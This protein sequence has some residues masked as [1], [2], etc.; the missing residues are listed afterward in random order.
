ML[1]IL[2]GGMLDLR[3]SRSPA[4]LPL[5]RMAV[6]A[7]ALATVPFTTPHFFG[8]ARGVA[9][10][11]ALALCVIAWLVWLFADRNERAVTP[12]MIV[13]GGAGGVL[14]GLSSLSLA[15]AIGCVVT[16]SAAI[17]MSPDHSFAVTAETSAAF[18]LAGLIAGASAATL[19]GYTCAFVGLWALGLTRHQSLMRAEE[20]ER[21]LEQT[22]R[23]REAET[24]A[25]ALTERARLAR[26]IHDVLAH[27]LA[28]V[29]VNLQAAE[30][31][32]SGLPDQGPELAKALECIERAG[33][34][35]RE[36]LTEARHA[37]NA[38]RDNT[39]PLPEQLEALA[40]RYGAA[41][42]AQAA[43]S[44]IG[45]PRPVPPDVNLTTYRAAQEALTNAR[46]HSPGQPVRLRLE[47]A[48]AEITLLVTNPLPDA[49]APSPAAP[50]SAPPAGRPPLAS[51]GGGHGLTGLRERAAL[52]GGTLTA[53]P[54]AGQWQVCLRIPA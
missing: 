49:A 45:S 46:K 42:D 41:G 10:T 33:V 40:T 26:E 25:A 27:S 23:A 3:P 31:L 19:I 4:M 38:L 28:A 53:G 51:T 47:F 5:I 34:F 54:A 52:S 37:I 35:T 1:R 11:I 20:A 13:L 32:L 50:G 16:A 29:S 12:A 2:S 21:R 17:R 7:A 30:G 9:D 8:G 43:F 24:Q 36:G 39:S 14:A 48:P 18:L 15:M 44:L 22:R 6:I